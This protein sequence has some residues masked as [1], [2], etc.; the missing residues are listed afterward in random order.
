MLLFTLS[1]AGI[2]AFLMTSIMMVIFMFVKYDRKWNL[3]LNLVIGVVLVST[4]AY[5]LRSYFITIWERLELFGLDD[6]G[7]IDLWTEAWDKFR[8]HPIFGAG[9]FAR[10]LEELRLYHNTVLNILAW[11]GALGGVA[12]LIQFVSLLR[13]FLTKINQRKAILLIAL[14]GVNLHGMVDNIYMMP[15]YMIILF[16][17]VAFVENATKVDLL[18]DQLRVS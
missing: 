10:S 16:V 11:F 12:L 5:F 14:I 4:I 8:L 3:F 18:R 2:I 17:T 6:N 9:I 15:Q 13:I 7:R 1:R